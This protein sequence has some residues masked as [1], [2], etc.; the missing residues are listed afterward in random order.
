MQQFQALLQESEH[1]IEDFSMQKESIASCLETDVEDQIS[2]MHEHK[3]A[4]FAL[5]QLAK[6]L[7]QSHATLRVNEA[8]LSDKKHQLQQ[9]RENLI[10]LKNQGKQLLTE[11]TDLKTLIKQDSLLRSVQDL[12]LQLE[13]DKPCPLCGSLSHP[14]I[15]DRPKLDIESTEQRLNAKSE[16]LEK[17]VVNTKN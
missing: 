14:A 16:A 11:E 8:E 6:S 15:N 5:I 17:S 10:E 13:E 3:D 4:L 2:R 9:Q 12:Q 1:E 7:N